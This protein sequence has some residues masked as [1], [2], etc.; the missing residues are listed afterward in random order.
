MLFP[1]FYVQKKSLKKSIALY[2]NG[3]TALHLGKTLVQTSVLEANC[4][5][6]LK[7]VST[8]VLRHSAYLPTA[9]TH[10]TSAI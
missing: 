1:I 9:A 3:T 4:L 5:L 8:T 2:H 10:A 6:I 7:N